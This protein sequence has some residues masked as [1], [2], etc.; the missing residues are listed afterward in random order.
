MGKTD[1]QGFKEYSQE[2]DAELALV[3]FTEEELIQLDEVLD[4]R[5]RLKKAQSLRRHK[6]QINIGRKRAAKRL[7]SM[8]KIKKRALGRAKRRLISR[9]TQGRGKAQLSYGGR[10]QL[11]KRLARM[12]GGIS[13][14]AVKLIRQVKQDDIAKLKGKSKNKSKNQR[15]VKQSTPVASL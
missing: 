11:E 7:A 8:D 13:R 14:L 12:K 9:L 10:Q 15:L 3:E 2:F 5:A 4:T 1:M 6:A